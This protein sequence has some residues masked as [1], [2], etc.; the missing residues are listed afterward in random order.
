MYK[1]SFTWI[2]AWVMTVIATAVSFTACSSDEDMNVPVSQSSEYE[3]LMDALENYSSLFTAE[4]GMVSRGDLGWGKFKE[5][6]KADHLGYNNGSTVLSISASRKKW[7]E[8]KREELQKQLETYEMAPAERTA[9]KAQ[10]DSLK[11][12]YKA[13]AS[14]IGAIHNAVILQTLLDDD[15][16]FNTTEELVQSV[17]GAMNKLDVSVP[18]L[19]MQKTV[20]E[21]NEAHGKKAVFVG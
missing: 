5:S 18:N 8:L 1:K 16:D 2:M 21:V 17:V 3:E 6:V 11:S 12:I 20:E 7:K 14:N 19:D 4:H 13:D 15:M 10:V 9:I